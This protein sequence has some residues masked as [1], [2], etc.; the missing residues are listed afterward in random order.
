MS[1]PGY[2]QGGN[3][4]PRQPYS[5]GGA[6][7]PSNNAP[8]GGGVFPP[9]V[10]FSMNSPIYMPQPYPT[11]GSAYPPQAGAGYPSQGAGHP[12]QGGAGYPPQGGAS[13]YPS[14]GGS[15][16]SPHGGAGYPS[17]GGSHIAPQGGAGFPPHGGSHLPPQGGVGY[18]SHGGAYPPAPTGGAPPS[19]SPYPS[20]A[21]GAPPHG[22][23]HHGGGYPQGHH[24]PSGH[25]NYYPNSTQH[26]APFHKGT[27]T[28]VP[29]HPFDP[30]ADAEVLRRAMKGFGTDEA[31][32][33][34]VLTRRTNVQ[35]LQIIV[36]FKTMYGKDLIS[37]LKSELSGN[38]ENVIVAMMTPLPQYYAKE[39][40]RAISGIGTD[41]DILIEIMCTLSNSEIRTI[42]QAYHEHYRSSLES[43][44]KGDSSGTFKRLMVSLC[45]AGRDESM[46]TDPHQA[47]YDAQQLLRA[48]EL[49]LGTDESTFNM[50]LCQR[51][52]AQLRLIFEEYQ[53]LTGHDIEKAIKNEFS[54]NSENCLLSIVRAIK[55]KPAFFAKCLHKYMEG[56]GTEDKNLIRVIVTR[57]EIDMQEI[58]REYYTMYGKSLKDRLRDECSGDYKRCLYALIGEP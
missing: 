26:V 34:N 45:A 15:S 18:P 28:V 41:E 46:V 27:P 13:G 24:A 54:G 48:G 52:Y 11:S 51:N 38:F 55:N 7:Y 16:H 35:R 57:S 49:Q 1:Y 14:H 58:K 56:I 4:Y 30:R 12:P 31:A 22:G 37:D 3:N 47:R 44:L 42:R 19:S 21:G 17:H 9:S 53:H 23:H 36:E 6:P 50:I 32:I 10:G 33:I 8:Q 2:P 25:S 40:H 43:D 20:N 29:A 5:G 39:L